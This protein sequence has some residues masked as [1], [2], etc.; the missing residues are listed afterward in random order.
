MIWYTVQ[1]CDEILWYDIH[2]KELRCLHKTH[3]AKYEKIGENQYDL[4]W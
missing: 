2:N 1:I 4:K 3:A